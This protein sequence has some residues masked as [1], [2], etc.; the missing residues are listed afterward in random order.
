[1]LKYIRLQLFLVSKKIST[2]LIPLIFGIALFLSIGLPIILSKGAVSIT[3][4]DSMNYILPFIISAVFIAV[5]SLNIFKDSE[6]DGTEL[7]IVSKPITRSK[8]VFGKFF[9]LYILIFLFSVATFF[10]GFLVALSDKNGSVAQQAEFA[11]SVAFA[12][13][14]IEFLLSSIIVFFAS[15]LGKIGTMVLA[16]LFP[17]IFTIISIIVVPLSNS[18]IGTHYDGISERYIYQKDGTK[19]QIVIMN[20]KND[21]GKRELKKHVDSWYNYA[22]YIDVW[23]QL[24]S[25]Y[26]IFQK[27]DLNLWSTVKWRIDEPNYNMASATDLYWVDPDTNRK[28]IVASNY[29]LIN[30]NSATINAKVDELIKTTKDKQY[31]SYNDLYYKLYM[32]ANP[33]RP[34]PDP[35][36]DYNFYDTVASIAFVKY[37]N[38]SAN[39]GNVA[40]KWDSKTDNGFGYRS[41]LLDIS[42]EQV[43]NLK[44]AP[45]I[46]K[47]LMYIIWLVITFGIG[48]LV[49]LRYMRR[50]FK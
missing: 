23:G 32:S 8:I 33:D 22:A 7:L 19:T 40:A 36:F 13:F 39:Q 1:M 9:S 10:I 21:S 45:Y 11:A 37:M 14:I 43:S 29:P 24:S 15:V 41:N 38:D 20:N 6:I 34:D 2:Y 5:K 42:K 3:K 35:N 44:S 16:I 28:Y 31:T 17:L 49:M 12:T 25:F 4:I 47:S 46:P 27:Q 26:S 48:A 50:D 30:Q 18:S